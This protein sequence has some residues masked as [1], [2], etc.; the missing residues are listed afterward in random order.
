VRDRASN[1][2]L[3]DAISAVYRLG[4]INRAR[5]LACQ[6]GIGPGILSIYLA[7][8]LPNGHNAISAGL[9]SAEATLDQRSEKTRNGHFFPQSLNKRRDFPCLLSGKSLLNELIPPFAYGRPRKSRLNRG[10]LD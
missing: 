3:G 5:I 4:W 6:A 1:T 10:V 2:L 9:T 7:D 8:H